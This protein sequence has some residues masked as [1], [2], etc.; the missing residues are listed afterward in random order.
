MIHRVLKDRKENVEFVAVLPHGPF[1]Q[2][3]TAASEPRPQVCLC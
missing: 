3:G 2:A 1:R